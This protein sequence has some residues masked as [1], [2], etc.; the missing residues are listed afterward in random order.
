MKITEFSFEAK[1]TV[2][3]VEFRIA[4]ADG[5]CSLDDTVLIKLHTDAG[6]IGYGEA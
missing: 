5:N 1:K 6:L 4:L 2:M 3:N